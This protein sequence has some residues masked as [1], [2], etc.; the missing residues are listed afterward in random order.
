M[1]RTKSAEYLSEPFSVDVIIVWYVD[2][3]TTT[4]YGETQSENLWNWKS[5]QKIGQKISQKK[6]EIISVISLELLPT[7]LNDTIYI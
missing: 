4:W 1:S 5:S 7:E 2:I 6:F 3:C